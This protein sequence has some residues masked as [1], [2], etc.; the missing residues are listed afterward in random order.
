MLELPAISE[1]LL[2]AEDF[3]LQSGSNSSFYLRGKWEKK[4]L[5]AIVCRE[6]VFLSHI[7]RPGIC[8]YLKLETFYFL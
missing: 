1:Y 3:S 2:S 5:E 6:N 4:S 7:P 8:W